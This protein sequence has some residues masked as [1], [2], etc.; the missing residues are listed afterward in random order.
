MCWGKSIKVGKYEYR[1]FSGSLWLKVFFHNMSTLCGF[2]SE[3]EAKLC[4]SENKYSILSELNSSLKQGNNKFEFLLEYPELGRMN[5]WQQTNSPLDEEEHG[6]EFVEG[7]KDIY[8]GA[9]R[10]TWGGLARTT[11]NDKTYTL[12]N[13]SPS[14]NYS[15]WYFA[16][17]MYNGAY[18]S[19]NNLPSNAD[20]TNIVYLWVKMPINLIK[21]QPRCS[22]SHHRF[23]Y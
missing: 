7:Y 20:A 19:G 8:I 3:E 21:T 13:G 2:T 4:N 12:I 14:V 17:G 18:W 6:Q 23:I 11:G 16:I 22:N 10:S 15:D 9:P 5:I 1:T